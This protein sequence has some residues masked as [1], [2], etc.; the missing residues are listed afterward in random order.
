MADLFTN[1]NLCF[2][3]LE[4]SPGRSHD[5]W[6]NLGCLEDGKGRLGDNAPNF[7]KSQAQ[8]KRKASCK[9]RR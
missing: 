8:A 3:S 7:P 5:R 4:D 1:R 9:N 2:C 6:D